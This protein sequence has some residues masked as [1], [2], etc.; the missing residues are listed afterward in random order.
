MKRGASRGAQGL[1]RIWTGGS[2][3]A[4]SSGDCSRCAE[5]RGGAQD[6]ADIAGILDAR[7]NNEKRRAGGSGSA[8]QVV[9]V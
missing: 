9:E 2:G 1:W 3:L 8:K 6:R 7:E 4:G 5:S